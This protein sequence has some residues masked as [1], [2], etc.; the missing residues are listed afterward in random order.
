MRQ[1]FV[2]RRIEQADG[3]RQRRH[4]PED[5]LEI[6][7]L[8]REQLGERRAAAGLVVGEDHL[9]DVGDPLGIEEH[10]LGPAQADALGA[11]LARGAAVERGLGI[12]R[13]P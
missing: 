5:L 12:G 3:D 6:G 10:M 9:A 4:D 1:E 8:G 13:G 2:E 7:A 11:E